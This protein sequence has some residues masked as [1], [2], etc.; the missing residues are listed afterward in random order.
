MNDL[1]FLVR[2]IQIND[3]A[4]ITKIH[5]ASFQDRALTQLGFGAVKRYYSWLLSGFPEAYPICVETQDGSLAGF[6]F[7]GHY[8]GSFS[9]F[10]KKHTWYLVGSLLLRPWL[11][12]NPLVRDQTQ[13][14][15]KALKKMIKSRKN[16]LKNNL[17][18]S[19]TNRQL[20]TSTSFGVLS[21][22]VSPAHQ[23]HGLG[24]LLM[25]E[26]E[27]FANSKGYSRLHL[28]VHPENLPAVKFYEKLG[29]E[30][31]SPIGDW[32]GKMHKTIK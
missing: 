2:N 24:E 31:S 7:A 17:P 20:I 18:S 27:K 4:E 28:S 1:H 16:K 19:K 9:G 12:I 5:I 13:V 23:R 21:I 8:S 10:L 25:C 26:V 3:L 30:R 29:W 11:L 15:I 6:C 14:A 32:D 22:A